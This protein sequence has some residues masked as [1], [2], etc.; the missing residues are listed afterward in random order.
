MASISVLVVVF[1]VA[2]LYACRGLDAKAKVS[3]GVKMG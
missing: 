1:I 2:R 3:F